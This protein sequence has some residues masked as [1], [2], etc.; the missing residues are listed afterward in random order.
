MRA[1]SCVSMVMCCVTASVVRAQVIPIRQVGPAEAVAEKLTIPALTRPLSDGRLIVGQGRSLLLFNAEL[2]SPRVVLDSTALTSGPGVSLPFPPAFIAGLADTTFVVDYNGSSL[3]TIEPSGKVGRVVALP[4]SRDASYLAFAFASMTTFT[5]PKGRLVYRASFPSPPMPPPAADGS[6]V[7]PVQPDTFPIIRADF[8]TRTADTLA[9]LKIQSFVR[10]ISTMG[11]NNRITRTTIT[12]PYPMV[13]VWTLLPDG[14]V[15]IVR[16]ND[17]HVDW[18]SPDGKRSSSP[19]MP[20][21]WRRIADEDK[22]RIIDSVKAVQAVSRARMDSIIKAQGRDPA[23]VSIATQDVVRPNELPDYFP[24]VRDAGILA[25]PDG[26]VWVLPTTSAGAKN[27]LLYDV[28]NRKGEIFE[29]VQLP[30]G[31]SLSALAKGGVIYLL[32][33]TPTEP[34]GTVPSAPPVARLERR[35]V[36]PSAQ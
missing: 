26:N 30:S 33:V 28:I 36:I 23:T 10:S 6:R 20:F 31:C 17:Y 19:K 13:D 14:T 24:P 18:I 8:D 9:V 32:C 16:G 22:T 3:L 34:A 15:A 12:Q 5:D 1:M 2:A 4:R 29:R 35:R 25:D 21:D 7:M 11:A 27:G